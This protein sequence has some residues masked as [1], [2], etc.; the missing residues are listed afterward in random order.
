MLSVTH[1]VSFGGACPPN[2]P[3]GAL[4]LDP[5]GG[6]PSP[7]PTV[8][9]PPNPGYATVLGRCGGG[10]ES[11]HTMLA[12][13]T[14]RRA[15]PSLYIYSLNPVQPP[16]YNVPSVTQWKKNERRLSLGGKSPP[17]FACIRICK[18]RQDTRRHCRRH[19]N[20][21]KLLILD[22]T[23]TV[24][25]AAVADDRVSES[26]IARFFSSTSSLISYGTLAAP[27][28]VAN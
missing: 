26:P 28:G 11:S 12:L 21:D 1:A 4:P 9:L 13:T 7:K 25:S 22:A 2:P 15:W 18:G 3:Q 16:P 19:C 14:Q 5:A 23:A 24:S 20:A 10:G 27:R 6:L 17:S 8:P